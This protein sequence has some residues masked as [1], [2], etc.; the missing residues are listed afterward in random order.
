MRA[1]PRF[2]N[3]GPRLSLPLIS[4]DAVC[5][6]PR[7]PL[8]PREHGRTSHCMSVASRGSFAASAVA[9]ATV[10][11][12]RYLG[13]MALGSTAVPSFTVWPNLSVNTD[14]PRAALRARGGSPV[15]FVR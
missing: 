13:V 14:A 12:R 15:T 4:A 5:R 10:C 1:R 11:G 2:G 3:V 9:F 6:N 7:R 8:V